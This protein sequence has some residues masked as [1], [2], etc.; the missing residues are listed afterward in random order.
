MKGVA[1]GK[2]S[3]NCRE[4]GRQFDAV[5]VAIA[6]SREGADFLRAKDPGHDNARIVSELVNCRSGIPERIPLLITEIAVGCD[7]QL[8]RHI[9]Q[10][11]SREHL[12]H[13]FPV[14]ARQTAFPRKLVKQRVGI[15]VGPCP[16][17]PCVPQEALPA[18]AV[19]ASV[20][21]CS[22]K[23]VVWNLGKRGRE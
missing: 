5:F 7:G 9:P 20:P 22:G 16:C 10:D 6:I 17:Q 8:T 14:H 18:P 15:S 2:S 11:R 13:Q 21:E 12:F 4:R 19:K 3:S 23:I 1:D